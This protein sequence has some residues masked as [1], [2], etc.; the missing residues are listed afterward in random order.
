MTRFWLS[1]TA[2]ESAMAGF[3]YHGPWWISGTQM[4]PDEDRACVCMAAIAKNERL[5][6]DL[7]RKSFDDPDSLK[8]FR[9]VI[10]RPDDWDALA[11]EGGRFPPAEW[12]RWPI[13]ANDALAL[14]GHP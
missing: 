2:P 9:F 11:S 14:R 8:E 3:E 4:R 7:A 10:E 5:V 1:F 12:M 13:T 6:M